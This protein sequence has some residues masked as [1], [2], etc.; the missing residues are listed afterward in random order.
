MPLLATPPITWAYKPSP[1]ESL[2]H[3][4]PAVRLPE[5]SVG[6]DDA[7]RPGPGGDACPLRRVRGGHPAG[8]GPSRNRAGPKGRQASRPIAHGGEA[9]RLHLGIPTPPVEGLL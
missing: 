2:W 6:P 8:A 1:S 9:D 5:R 3:Q 7:E 4:G